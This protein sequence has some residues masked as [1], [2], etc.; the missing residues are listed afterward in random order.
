MT[1]TTDQ[2]PRGAD[3]AR[4]A[5]LAARRAARLHG[6]APTKK[7]AATRQQVARAGRDARDPFT[8]AAVMP[9][10]AAAHGWALGTAQGT[11]RD[12]WAQLV[13]PQAALHW[14]PA[15]FNADTRTLRVTCDSPAWATKLRLDQRAVLA[16]LNSA[17]PDTVR[18]LDIR[19]GPATPSRAPA[20]ESAGPAEQG[21][22]SP[23][24]ITPPLAD[25]PNYQQL[26][27][28]MRDQ[29]IARQVA[30]DQTAAHLTADRDQW[31]H[32]HR[33]WL[34][35]PEG[36]QPTTDATRR[37]ETAARA[38]AREQ[39]ARHHAALAAARAQRA[40]AVPLRPVRKP[41]SLTGAA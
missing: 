12:T 38:H 19:V 32:G 9:A 6:N 15:G 41:T 39:L 13:G 35:E 2:T 10:M 33:G 40:G 5:L 26:R 25:N 7:P 27:Q 21:D 24:S 28:Q 1:S 30:L 14:F 16:R 17:R 11:L 4:T 22:Q 18:A 37:P 8:L 20:T 31:F 29:A 3:A 34:R 23:T 36:A